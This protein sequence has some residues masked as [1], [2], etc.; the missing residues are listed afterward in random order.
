KGPTRWVLPLVSAFVLALALP[1]AAASPEEQPT[2]FPG[3]PQF[4]PGPPMGD[5]DGDGISDDLEARLAEARPG[6]RFGVIVTL[7]GAANAASAERAVGPFEVKRVFS[8][9]RGFAATMTRA[10]VEALAG[11][12]GVLRI[13]EDFEVRAYLD[14][15]RSDF[16]VDNAADVFPTVTGLDVGICVV[17]SGMD[18]SHEQLDNGKVV[19]FCN[20][21]DGGCT[22]DG[23]GDAVAVME[24]APFDDH[25]HG[26]HVASIAAGDG[27]GGPKAA[28]YRGVAWD[29]P[30][31]GAK[32]LKSDGT[33]TAS[34]IIAGIDWCAGQPGVHVLNLSLGGLNT[35]DGTD[36][37]STAANCA[38][39][40]AWINPST[41]E[42][43][44]YPS[45]PPRVVV[46]AAGNAGPA[47]F[48]ISSPAAAEQ[49]I[50]VGAV[51]DWS[52]E[53]GKYRKGLAAFSS[54]GPT[55][56]FRTKPDVTAPGVNITAAKAGKASNRYVTFN[57]TSMAA[58]FVAG[59]AA[60]VLDANPGLTPQQVKDVFR[61]TAQYRG[62][63]NAENKNYD[64]GWGLVDVFAAVAEAS[65]VVYEP[66]AFP[67]Y[68][69]LDETIADFTELNHDF[70]VSDPDMEIAVTITNGGAWACAWV[71]FLGKLVCLQTSSGA[72]FDAELYDPD[73]FLVDESTCEGDGDTFCGTGEWFAMGITG[74]MGRQETLLASPPVKL[75]TWTVRIYPFNGNALDDVA[76]SPVGVDLSIGPLAGTAPPPP[77]DSSPTASITSPSA[78]DVVS[79]SVMVTANATD[80]VGVT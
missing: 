44:P 13:E 77:P 1:A 60:L 63:P 5:R 29:A 23:D 43:C 9:I 49:P 30:L 22:V 74:T 28:T 41:G 15:A 62:E 67:T 72:D 45:R 47:H 46:L 65:N 79:G 58:P 80:D 42:P 73:G 68:V 56:D 25:G 11:T 54:R 59:A 3:A 6:D 39:D 78:G 51:A 24:T 27:V 70:Y 66:T 19:G 14:D 38:A 31:Y 75:G 64:W 17:D 34:D 53:A 69:R 2:P 55:S 50:T 61:V 33:G 71:V 8:I 7:S 76:A 4:P 21:V 20:A 36:V 40:P 10:Q 26:T 48:Q 57:G 35:S 12:P 18:A 37:L 16:G 32:V 52:D